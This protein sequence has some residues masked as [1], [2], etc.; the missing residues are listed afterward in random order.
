[1][2]GEFD[3][4]ILGGIK[5][6]SRS[7]APGPEEAFRDHSSSWTSCFE[8]VAL[9]VAHRG[10]FLRASKELLEVLLE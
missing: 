5:G 1:M 8:T 6:D 2:S 9:T 3:H 4:A 7:T 10:Q